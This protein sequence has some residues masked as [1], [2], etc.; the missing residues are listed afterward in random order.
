MPFP[1]GLTFLSTPS[2]FASVSV[3]HSVRVVFL[4]QPQAF[5]ESLLVAGAA[6]CGVVASVGILADGAS[7]F[8]NCTSLG[9]VSPTQ[10]AAWEKFPRRL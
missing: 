1:G 9:F 4:P 3:R 5:S 2:L 8:S 6:Q 10:L 7:C